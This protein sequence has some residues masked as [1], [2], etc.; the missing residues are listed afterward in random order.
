MKPL[1]ERMSRLGTETA[2]EVLAKAK[3]LEAKGIDVVHLE[4][5]EPDFDTP[6]NIKYAAIE[7][8][9]EG[10]THYNPSQGLPETRAAIAE[11][12]GRKRGIKVNPENVIVVPGGKP[13]ITFTILALVDEGDEVIYPDPGYPIYESVA[14]FCGAKCIPIPLREENEFRL[15]VNELEKLVNDKTKLLVINSPQNP[16]GGMLTREDL[17]RIAELA[18]KY[19]FYVLADEIYSEIIY[20]GEH[21]S[22]LQFDGMKDR[23]IVLDGFSKTYA[24]T[25]WRIGY[26]IVPDHLIDHMVR[27]ETNF[28]SCTTTF[29]QKAAIEALTGPQDAVRAM[30]EEFRERR[31][32]IVDGVNSIPG[33]SCLK[34]KGAFYVFVNIK[35]TGMAA[36]EMEEF[37]LNEAHVAALA[38]TSFGKYGE[39]YIRFSYANSIE[40]INK[41]IE[42]IREALARRG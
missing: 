34:P 6:S 12:F 27:L 11:Y 14:N 37:L 32:V 22:I 9:I 2:F 4:I 26:G 36:K 8:M 35:E 3:A 40:N 13:I 28:N 39:G 38:G 18:V 23:T 24:M 10:Y 42:R 33:L 16:T 15:D 29:I 1:A 5:G 30:V 17:K 21:E 20:E 25:G 31:D 7:A 19:D 41:A